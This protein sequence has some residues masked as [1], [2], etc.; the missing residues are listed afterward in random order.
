[1]HSLDC[2][3]LHVCSLCILRRLIFKHYLFTYLFAFGCVGSLLLHRLF[4][5]CSEWGLFSL[6]CVGFP[7][8]WLLLWSTGCSVHGLAVAVH[9]VSCSVA[10]GIFPD[11]GLNPPLLHWQ[12]DSLLLSHQG[13][14]TISFNSFSTQESKIS[15]LK[16]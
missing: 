9:G 6:Q 15:L 2:T 13:S 14:P 8:R 4:S 5:G 3:Y 7:L 12:A 1:M 11:Q 10:Y 16:M